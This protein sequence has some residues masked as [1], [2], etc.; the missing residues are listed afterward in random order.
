MRLLN[1]LPQAGSTPFDIALVDNASTDDSVPYVREHF[2]HVHIVENPE[3]LG[4]TG[5]FNSGLRYGLRHPQ[6]YDYFWLLDNDVIAHPG[7]LDALVEPMKD[8]KV[9]L[10]GST[11]TLIDDM[12]HVQEVGARVDW[13]TGAPE[14]IGEGALS[15]LERPRLHEVD[16]VAA[17]SLL[18]RVP[19][20]RQ[21]GLWDAN[22]FL[23]WDDM[24][25]GIRF[26]RAGWKVVATTESLIGHE[27]FDKRRSAAPIASSYLWN[28]NAYYCMKKYCPTWTK[29]RM[30]FHRFRVE[31]AYADNFDLDGFHLEASALKLA[32][33]DFFR[34]KMGK[35][36]PELYQRSPAPAPWQPLET[37]RRNEVL[38]LALLGN[39]N[40]ELTRSMYIAMQTAFPQARIDTLVFAT[41][42]ELLREKFE[43]RRLVRARS[44]FDRAK[45]AF[46]LATQYDAVAAWLYTPRHFWEK[47]V[48]FSIRMDSDHTWEAKERNLPQ[49]LQ[50][51]L[52]RVRAIMIAGIYMFRALVMP[53]PRPD[54]FDF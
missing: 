50:I 35:P 52:F 32:I 46:L 11:V 49:I 47:F 33:N 45:L 41:R 20:V 13:S 21:V 40:P 31:L 16:Y 4:G 28:R 22:Y 15:K 1:S 34:G 10:V 42:E 7:C 3:N 54:Y 27:S 36:V 53:K 9:G 24:E 18:A 19:A 30:F 48:K 14:R 51:A 38:R 43:N 12:S 25:W 44:L 5:G 23:M 8:S 6:Q 39:D 26:N 17:C 37:G 2:P 29:P